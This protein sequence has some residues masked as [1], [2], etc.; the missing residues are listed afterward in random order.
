[1]GSKEADNPR[2]R[3]TRHIRSASQLPTDR[4][5]VFT[6]TVCS[7]GENFSFCELIFTQKD[8]A[9]RKMVKENSQNLRISEVVTSFIKYQLSW[10]VKV[11]SVLEVSQS[12]D[13]NSDRVCNFTHVVSGVKL[14]ITFETMYELAQLRSVLHVYTC[15]AVDAV[16]T[17]AHVYVLGRIVKE[18]YS[19]AH[20][21]K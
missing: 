18:C 3:T 16:E 8:H 20:R 2:W 11:A 15:N 9:E 4:C 5:S 19:M 13:Q 21:K 17:A 1:M 14:S 7:V 12:R 6:K 10:L